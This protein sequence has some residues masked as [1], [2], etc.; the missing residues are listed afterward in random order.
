VL[1]EDEPG[2]GEVVDPPEGWFDDH[3]PGPRRRVDLQRLCDWEPS[4]PD[5]FYQEPDCFPE[6]NWP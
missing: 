6:L 5:Y 4:E 1:E 2:H 3:D